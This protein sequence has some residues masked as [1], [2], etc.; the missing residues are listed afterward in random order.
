MNA[1]DTMKAKSLYFSGYTSFNNGDF[2]GAIALAT[3]CLEKAPAG[4]YWYAGALGL[5]CWAANY[6][7]DNESVEHDAQKLLNLD[8]GTEKPWFDG[9]AFLNLGFVYQRKGK[10][11]EAKAF[12]SDASDQYA[13]Y[14]IQTSQPGEWKIISHFFVAM[15]QMAAFEKVETLEKVSDELSKY[16]ASSEEIVRFRQAVNLYLRRFHGENVSLEAESAAQ[17]GVSR[18]FLSLILLDT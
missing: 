13:T 6:L 5:R 12:F 3:Q 16:P 10:V 11:N 18:A 14:E 15:A 9:L 7:G 8:T 17:N 4:S 2:Q 1:N